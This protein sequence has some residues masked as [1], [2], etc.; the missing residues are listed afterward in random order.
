VAMTGQWEFTLTKISRGEMD[1]ATFHRSIEVY[2]SQ[3]AAEL[4]DIPFERQEDRPGCD[5]PKCKNGKVLFFPKVAKCNN[6]HC[7]LV[8]FRTIAKKELTDT[9]LTTLLTNKKTGIIKGFT[10]S[11]TGKPFDAAVVFDTDYKTVFE[12]ENKG[13]KKGKPK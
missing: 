13:G 2:A 7:G 3:I 6:E 12:F 1:A 4:L 8:V 10:S 11:K 9:Q 5:C